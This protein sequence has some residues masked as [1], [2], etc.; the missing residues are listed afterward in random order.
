MI[1]KATGLV[2]ILLPGNTPM[3][4]NENIYLLDKYLKIILTYL[5][6]I[7]PSLF[8]AFRVETIWLIYFYFFDFAI[9]QE[10]PIV[11]ILD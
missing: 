5:Q 1:S 2:Y 10:N 4:T 3:Y 7:L 6:T 9:F 11:L 8:F